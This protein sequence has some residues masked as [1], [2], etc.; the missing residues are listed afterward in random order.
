MSGS[1]VI[2]KRFDTPFEKEILTHS[3]G[4]K[5]HFAVFIMRTNPHL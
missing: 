2:S 3:D 1:I 5:I 4:T